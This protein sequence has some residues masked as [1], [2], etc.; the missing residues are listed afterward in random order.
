MVTQIAPAWQFRL[1]RRF[2]RMPFAVPA[3]VFFQGTVFTAQSQNLSLGGMLLQGTCDFPML[4]PLQVCF[5]L[6]TGVSIL[7]AARVVHCRPAVRVGVEFLNL[8]SATLDALRQAI[9]TEQSG[10]RRSI[11]IPERLYLYLQWEQDGTPVQRTAETILL[12]RHG[13]LLL[14]S[15][16]PRSNALLTIR[17][18][19]TGAVTSARVVSK[20]EYIDGMFKMALVFTEDANFWG[21]DFAAEETKLTSLM[22]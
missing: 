7:A 20:E 9:K 3:E 10:L 22:G 4:A 11:R 18:P 2:P 1:M 15:G 16:A 14:S 12:S 8:E 5:P 6:P 17:W 13:C 19:D 21:I